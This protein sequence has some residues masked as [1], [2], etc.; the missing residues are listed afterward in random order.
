MT[1]LPYMPNNDDDRAGLLEHIA[2]ALPHYA[3][4]L[5]ISSQ[6]L[7]GIKADSICFRYALKR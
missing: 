1:N 2:T 5:E 7:E 6:D 4:L 3:E